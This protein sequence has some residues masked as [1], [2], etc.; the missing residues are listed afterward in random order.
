MTII[1]QVSKSICNRVPTGVTIPSKR[2]EQLFY[3]TGIT[4]YILTYYRY[5][6]VRVGV[7]DYSILPSAMFDKRS[8]K[9]IQLVLPLRD[10]LHWKR[11]HMKKS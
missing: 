1:I 8:I 7:I 6:Q 2:D 4:E 10:F 5:L 3:F 9:S 11:C